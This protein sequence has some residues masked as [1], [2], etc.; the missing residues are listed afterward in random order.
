[1]FYYNRYIPM[2]ALCNENSKVVAQAG[3]GC[4]GHSDS[5]N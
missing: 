1:V 4:H 2:I 3:S 5:E